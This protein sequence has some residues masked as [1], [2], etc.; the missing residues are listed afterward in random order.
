MAASRGL[1]ETFWSH[2]G[3][4]WGVLGASR[5][6]LGASWAALGASWA[7]LGRLLGSSSKNIDFKT[8][9]G[10]GPSRLWGPLLA[11]KIDPRRSPKRIKI[12]DVFQ[13]RKKPSSRPSW[14]RLGSILGRL[15]RRLGVPGSV[16]VLENVVRE[17][18]RRFRRRDVVKTHF[19]ANL[20]QLGRQKVRK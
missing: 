7:A 5:G 8:A 17:Q 4:S 14:S 12:Q 15:G 9:Q 1:L 20:S 19:A 11:P 18:N 2:L 3:P 13:E 10:G 16:F 6:D